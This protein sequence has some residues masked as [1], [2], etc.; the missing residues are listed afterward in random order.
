MKLRTVS[1]VL[2][3]LLFSGCGGDFNKAVHNG[4]QVSQLTYDTAMN[5]VDVAERNDAITP[6]LARRILD[7]EEKYRSGHNMI[8]SLGKQHAAFKQAGVQEEHLDGLEV[9]IH[10]YMLGLSELI[11]EF[12]AFLQEFGIYEPDT[13][14]SQ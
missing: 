5:S 11:A 4:L 2:L 1:L 13:R 7:Y 12:V 10:V 8:A 14:T 9:R 3:L 6:P